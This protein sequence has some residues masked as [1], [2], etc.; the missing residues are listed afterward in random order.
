MCWLYYFFD[1]C[2][3]RFIVSGVKDVGWC[4]VCDQVGL[5]LCVR[6]GGIGDVDGDGFVCF[7][8]FVVNF[9]EV[10]YRCV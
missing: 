9:V 10:M 3:V 6:Y 2:C 7:M 1:I 4:D 8:Y 5:Q